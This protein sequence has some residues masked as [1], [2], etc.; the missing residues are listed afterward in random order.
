[1]TTAKKLLLKISG[2]GVLMA[3]GVSS[4]FAALPAV[5]GTTLTSIEDDGLAL[6]D[7]VWPV[8]LGIMGVLIL[9]KLA[10]RFGGK[11]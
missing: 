6:A 9:M 4:A 11:I 1:M 10:K 5:V 7:L 2:A 3:A 8:I